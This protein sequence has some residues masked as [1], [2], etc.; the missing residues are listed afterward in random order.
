[1][2]Y[3][4][5]LGAHWNENGILFDSTCSNFACGTFI[6]LTYVHQCAQ[7]TL[8]FMVDAAYFVETLLTDVK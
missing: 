1:M 6:C 2:I 4:G 5:G 7:A 3:L 8:M